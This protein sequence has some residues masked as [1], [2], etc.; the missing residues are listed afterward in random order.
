MLTSMKRALAKA[1]LL[2]VCLPPVAAQAVP[3]HV[4]TV[5]ENLTAR[6]S[7]PLAAIARFVTWAY[8]V[9][10]GD[11]DTLRAAGIKTIYYTDPNLQYVDDPGG[12]PWI[13]GPR[14][15]GRDG[16][17]AVMT[18]MAARLTGYFMAV[19]DPAYI[20]LVRKTLA[21]LA[22][23]YDAFF[24]DDA[25]AAALTYNGPVTNPPTKTWVAFDYRNPA[26]Q[27]LADA[28]ALLSEGYRGTKVFQNSLSL[29]PNDG[30]TWKA[31]QA[32]NL[33]P[34]VIGGVDE[35]AFAGDTD[36]TLA[37]KAVESRWRSTLAAYVDTVRNKRIFWCL[38]ESQTDGDSA[39]GRD[40]R[41][42]VYASY[43][44]GYDGKALLQGTWKESH[45]LPVYPETCVVPE[46]PLDPPGTNPRRFAA[47][48]LAGRPVGPCAILVNPS[49]TQTIAIAGGLGKHTLVLKGGSVF[50]GGQVRL[51][52]PVPAQL[53]PAEAIILLP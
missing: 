5:V 17:D 29:A 23:H 15:N 37:H 50:E 16:K 34:N 49:A 3:T 35:L 2:C 10:P 19:G 53:G 14:Y 45:H 30:T 6:P 1:F 36:H 41:L 22:A 26:M 47:C 8:V 46:R 24:Y 11:T 27:A 44:L 18:Y 32:M 31:A 33:L 21:P 52:G 7:V 38:A 9:S 20:A 51:D 43:L 4:P 39:A 40:E 13:K 12:A 48:Y 28:R 25:L 42:Y